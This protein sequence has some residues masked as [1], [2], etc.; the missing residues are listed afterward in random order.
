MFRNHIIGGPA[1][2]QANVISGNQAS[3]VEISGS[4][5]KG[6][7]VQQ[8]LIGTNASGTVAIGNARAGVHI[9][10]GASRNV[11]MGGV[12]EQGAIQSVI[13]GNGWEG[14]RVDGIGSSENVIRSQFIGTDIHGVTAIPNA[15]AGI[16]LRGGSS[17]SVV[18]VSAIAGNLISGNTLDGVEV[19][20]SD[21]N[22]VFGNTIGLQSNGANQ[23][24]KRT[25][26]RFGLG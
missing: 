19:F 18:G 25:R 13:S 22:S 9:H 15:F 7:W 16:S 17:R 1:L 23:L 21:S 3:G 2:G 12:A 5:A 4:E 11:V 8:N 26:W 20:S 24:P 6:N 10:S 14:V